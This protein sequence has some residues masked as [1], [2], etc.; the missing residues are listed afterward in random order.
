MVVADKGWTLP[1]YIGLKQRLQAANTRIGYLDGRIKDKDAIGAEGG[2]MLAALAQMRWAARA[3]E[4]E[5]VV[6]ALP[7]L[8]IMTAV[9][10]GWTSVSREVIP[11]LYENVR[12]VWLGFQDPSV[13]LPALVEKVFTKRYVIEVPFR[14]LETAVTVTAKEAK[15]E[16]DASTPADAALQ[17][18]PQAED[19]ADRPE[20]AP[21]R[22]PN[23]VSYSWEPG[24]GRASC[25]DP[26]T[27]APEPPDSPTSSTAQD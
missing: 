5:D 23:A 3:P 11:L 14:T 6:F 7:H 19:S 8:D 15:E 17:P 4:A 25:D 9:E 21:R 20:S 18:I 16:P 1:L 27:N 12:S 22:D 10:G 2:V 26:P 13:T 24:T